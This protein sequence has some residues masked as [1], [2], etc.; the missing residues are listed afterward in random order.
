MRAP[1]VTRLWWRSGIFFAV[2]AWV[3]M[4]AAGSALASSHEFFA[5]KRMNILIGFPPAGG[6]DLEARIMARHLPN[7]IP[8][9]AGV[10][11]QN[12]PGA[13]GLMMG[14]HLYKRVKPDGLTTAVFGG[15]HLQSAILGEGVEYDVGKMN[16]IWAVS[17]VRVALVREFL[18]AKTAADLTRVPPDK[19][20]VSGRTKTDS[21]CM[22]GNLAMELLGIKGHKSVCA[23]AGTAVIKAAMERGEVSF[24]DASDAHLVGGGAYVEMY[25]KKQVVPVW[26]AG[27][28]RPDG[29]IA[30]SPTVPEGVPTFHE[31]YMQVHGK[32][33]TGPL[34]DAFRILY[35]TVHGSLTRVLVMPPGTPKNRIEFLRQAIESMTKD[36]AFV[37]DWEKVFGQELAPVVI[38]TRQAETHKEE[39]LKPAPWQDQL[40]KFI[41]F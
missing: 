6:H 40:R 27:Q 14:A 19:I 20:V 35:N 22:M 9:L 28:I 21:S 41:G 39:F 18:N 30:R 23:Y 4:T 16:L 38:P 37:R 17:G 7:H 26:Q 32:P 13:G 10:V 24:F 29:K 1:K 34:W 15:T 31:A 36:P 11:V 5:G 12:M 2:V 3:S 33:P 25:E 8:G